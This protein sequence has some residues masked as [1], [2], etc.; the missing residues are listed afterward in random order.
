MWIKPLLVGVPLGL[1][2]SAFLTAFLF[3][4]LKQGWDSTTAAILVPSSLGII[5]SCCAGVAQ[6][7]KIKAQEKE[8]RETEAKK[9]E[10]EEKAER[11]RM[12]AV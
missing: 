4:T 8:R 3:L 9:K 1:V 2:L 7:P 10:W 11:E 5:G 6:I 12:R